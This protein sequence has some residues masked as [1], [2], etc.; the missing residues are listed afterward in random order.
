M[1]WVRVLIWQVKRIL[2]NV[3]WTNHWKHRHIILLGCQWG[4]GY[5]LDRYIEFNI[6]NFGVQ[7][8][9]TLKS[10]AANLDIQ[11]TEPGWSL[12]AAYNQLK[13]EGDMTFDEAKKKWPDDKDITT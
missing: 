8:T 9:Y 5:S 6:L 2:R 10:K 11:I 4:A 12:R 13:Q 3:K 1:K 7:Y